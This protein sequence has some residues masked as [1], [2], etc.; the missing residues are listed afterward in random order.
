MTIEEQRNAFLHKFIMYNEERF[1]NKF[2]V[3]FY[4]ADIIYGTADE[5]WKKVCCMFRGI[6]IKGSGILSIIYPI[7]NIN[8]YLNEKYDLIECTKLNKHISDVVSKQNVI[9]ELQKHNGY[10]NLIKELEKNSWEHDIINDVLNYENMYEKGRYHYQVIEY[11][12]GQGMLPKAKW[13]LGK[14]C[15]ND[16]EKEHRYDDIIEK[17]LENNLSVRD[18]AKMV[19]DKIG[20]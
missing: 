14:G 13:I 20:N 17:G 18:C 5:I 4:V 12:A 7:L 6:V 10:E 2:P 15:I 1:N 8:P 16:Y 19:V 9:E 3:I 11:V